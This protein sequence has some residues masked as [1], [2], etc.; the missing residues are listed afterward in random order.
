MN[1]LTSIA[2]GISRLWA[3]GCLGKSAVIFA[4]L[5]VL[6]M[7]SSLLG[8]NRTPPAT[9][10]QPTIADAVLVA[11][12]APEPTAG[13]ASPEMTIADVPTAEVLAQLATDVPT[14]EQPTD[15]PAAAPTAELATDVPAP[16]DAPVPTAGPTEPPTPRLPPPI[17]PQ[18]PPSFANCQDDPNFGQA[19]NYPVLIAKVNKASEV[20]TLKNVSPDA[21]SLD[22]WR[23]CS[24]KGNQ[25]HPISGA[26][27]PGEQ[28]DF[29]GP[30]AASIW[31]NSDPDPGALYDGDGRLVS[32]WKN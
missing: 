19:P 3:R 16:T 32:Y 8:G 25:Q 17:Q 21:V 18:L 22:G 20:V 5:I 26:L 13:P 12:T 15:T 14:A 10:P 30:A 9:S 23:M 1:V 7:C 27:A 31:S 11:T 2:A 28:K 4:A 24:I 29:P 6:G